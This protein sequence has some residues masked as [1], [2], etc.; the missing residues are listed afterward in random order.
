MLHAHGASYQNKKAGNFGDIAVLS[1]QQEKFMLGDGGLVVC[2]TKKLHQGAT[3]L[4]LLRQR[5][6][7]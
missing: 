5:V 6:K 3:I 1:M 2:K 7:L 4:D